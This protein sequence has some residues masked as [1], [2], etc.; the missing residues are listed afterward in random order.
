MYKRICASVCVHLKMSSDF[1]FQNKGSPLSGMLGAMQGPVPIVR[2]YGI[3]MEGNSIMVHIHGFAPYF[4]VPAQPG[5]KK[6]HCQQFKVPTHFYLGSPVY[7][8][9]VQGS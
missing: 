4:F 9:H 2:M 5:F 7:R 8:Y 1:V 6:E 3:T